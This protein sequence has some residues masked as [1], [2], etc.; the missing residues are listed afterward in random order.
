MV[1]SQSGLFCRIICL[2]VGIP[3]IGEAGGCGIANL[4]QNV[5]EMRVGL[6]F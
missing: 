2:L 4:A 3:Q 1:K 5:I 6:S